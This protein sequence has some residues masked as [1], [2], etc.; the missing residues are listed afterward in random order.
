MLGAS[1]VMLLALAETFGQNGWA[2]E[3]LDIVA[4]AQAT[5][6][7]TGHRMA[8]A[9]LHRVKG[10]LLMIKDP[11]NVAEGERCLRAAIGRIHR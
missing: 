4:K 11:S 8:D 7:Q 10:E 2:D 5:E 3:G 6:E 1:I 9:E